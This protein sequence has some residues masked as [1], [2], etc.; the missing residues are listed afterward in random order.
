MSFTTFVMYYSLFKRE[1]FNNK[2]EII[3]HFPKN[4][5]GVFTT[6][7]RAN[8]LKSYPKD[9]HGCIGFWNNDFN[10]LS[11]KSLYDHLL[12]VS[13]DSVWEDRRNSF[14]EP[15]EREPETI[16]EI[17]FMLNP[18][19]SINQTTGMISGI[20]KRFSNKRFGIIIQSRTQKA[21]YLPNVFPDEAWTDIVESIKQKAG[22][23]SDNFELFAYKIHQIKSTYSTIL[24][25]NIFTYISIYHFS[26]V[27]IDN[28][29]L[30]LEFPFAYS[31]SQNQLEWNTT[32]QVR[33]ISTLS[34]I[35]KYTTIYKRIATKQEIQAIKQKILVILENIGEYSSQSL[36]FLGFIFQSFHL[37]NTAFCKKLLKD[38]PNAENDFEKPEIIIGLNKA[39]CKINKELLTFNQTD[40]IFRMNW[41]V[42]EI[43]SCK[44][45]PSNEL[46][47][48]LEDKITGILLNKKS[49]ETNY[50]AV[51]FESLC[52]A[53]KSKNKP[54]L[55]D[56]L[57]E[58]FFELEQRKNCN[59]VLYSFLDKTSRVDIT[60]HIL[61][62]LVQLSSP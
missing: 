28:M 35:Y 52:F 20:N 32:D 12:R 62:G 4:V 45:K 31:C 19:Y 27:L 41:V 54:S 38:L 21:T 10:N 14:F 37:N 44:K 15:I 57:F 53:Y 59:N 60:G 48:I 56:K 26:R 6:V 7:R 3:K 50:L 9:I 5:F 55:L 46:I 23:T 29:K 30:K 33:N 39:G 25:G 1:P 40:S 49:T 18:I 8:K 24:T 16:L 36:S 13:H 58:L 17:D 2:K 34:D 11:N 61:N 22:I 47:T 43:I 42:Q 51:A